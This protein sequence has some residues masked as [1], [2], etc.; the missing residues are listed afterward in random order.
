MANN[1][2]GKDFLLMHKM[3]FSKKR[4]TINPTDITIVKII[5]NKMN[6]AVSNASETNW[7][8]TNY[9]IDFYRA[10]KLIKN[11]NTVINKIRQQ[12][13]YWDEIPFL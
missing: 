3:F 2:N 6:N 1:G 7:T 8:G 5:K 11:T 12:N 13:W 9:K 10:F 4:L